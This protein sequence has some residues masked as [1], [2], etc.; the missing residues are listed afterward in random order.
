MSRTHFLASATLALFAASASAADFQFAELLVNP[1]GTDNGQEGI[2]I[3]GDPSASLAGYYLIIV[4][5]DGAGAGTI[6]VVRDL[7]ALAT[8]TNG[9]LLLRD[10]ASVILPGP[11]AATAIDVLDFSPDIENG[12][13]TYILG[14]GTPPAQGTDIDT[15]NDGVIDGTPFASFTVVDAVAILENDGAANVGYADDFGFENLGPFAGPVPDAHTPDAIHRIFDVDGNAFGWVGGDVAGT[16]PGGP[17]DFAIASGESF[18]FAEFGITAQAVDLGVPNAVKTLRGDGTT[19]VGSLGGTQT[20]ELRA[21][22]ANAGR[23]YY[24][25]GSVTGT[26]PGL[27]F[28]PAV[29][30]PLNYDFYFDFLV[31]NPN[32]L[33]QGSFATLDAAGQGSATFALPPVTLPIGV[34][35]DH[36]YLVLNAFNVPS[37]ASNAVPVTLEP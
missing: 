19:I 37:A 35:L 11:D 27:Q 22:V 33:V 14:F 16:N 24:V 1:P 29:L 8:G 34:T 36:A 28:S 32:T 23:G 31:S 18:G 10:S 13:N 30:L 12:S 17:Y 4:E 9:L 2:E 5:G 3:A 21:G 20:L 6:D 26:T 15:D 7:G 25:L